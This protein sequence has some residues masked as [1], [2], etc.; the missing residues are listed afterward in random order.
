MLAAFDW[1][2]LWDVVMNQPVGRRELTWLQDVSGFTE[3]LFDLAGITIVLIVI[4]RV[5]LS[6]MG[7]V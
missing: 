2:S 1:Q 5:C 4:G 3:D 6:D 7:G